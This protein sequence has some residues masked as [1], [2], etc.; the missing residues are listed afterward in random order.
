[1]ADAWRS[2]RLGV[3]RALEDGSGFQLYQL[4]SVPDQ[5]FRRESHLA[6][7]PNARLTIRQGLYMFL[8]RPKTDING[9]T[10]H[11]R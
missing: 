2:R 3:L 9:E 7:D 11:R 1:M 6:S 10:H 5:Q 4:G 8:A